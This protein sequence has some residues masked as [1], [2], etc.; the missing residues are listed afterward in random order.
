MW[1]VSSAQVVPT[2]CI[3]RLLVKKYTLG[4]GVPSQ[5]TGG[6][7]CKNLIKLENSEELYLLNAALKNV[8]TLCILFLKK[9]TLCRKNAALLLPRSKFKAQEVQERIQR[10]L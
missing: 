8:T 9:M 2:C 6:A 1:G 5:I 3:N 7:F 10:W 4:H